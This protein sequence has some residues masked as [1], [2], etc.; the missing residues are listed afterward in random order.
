MRFSDSS[1]VS[2][3]RSARPAGADLP[4]F[5]PFVMIRPHAVSHTSRALYH[6]LQT[7]MGYYLRDPPASRRRL[8]F[9]GYWLKPKD[10]AGREARLSSGPTRRDLF[11]SDANQYW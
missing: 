2:L 5:F 11:R 10:G 4:R 9:D 3:T 1:G 8:S 7:P 6:D